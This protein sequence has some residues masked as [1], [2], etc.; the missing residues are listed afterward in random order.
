MGISDLKTMQSPLLYK[1]AK[2]LQR[3]IE[4]VY[5]QLFPYLCNVYPEM[6]DRGTHTLELFTWASL[7]MWARAFT[8]DGTEGSQVSPLSRY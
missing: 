5:N 6:F 7:T 3:D 4:S 2:E 8:V 1:R